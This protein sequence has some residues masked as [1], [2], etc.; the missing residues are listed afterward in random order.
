MRSVNQCAVPIAVA[1]ADP[2][3]GRCPSQDHGCRH[4]A[5]VAEEAG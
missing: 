1:C 3:I 4:R 2:A 5:Y